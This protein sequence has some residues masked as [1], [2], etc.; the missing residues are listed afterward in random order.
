MASSRHDTKDLDITNASLEE[1][2]DNSSDSGEAGGSMAL[3]S[4]QVPAAQP[5]AVDHRYSHPRR[6]FEFR[7]QPEL[8][9]DQ[10]SF[11][12]AR[13]VLEVRMIS[14]AVGRN[15]LVQAWKEAAAV[16]WRKLTMLP[17]RA[18]F[19]GLDIPRDL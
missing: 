1:N 8:L 10:E 2:D 4:E 6:R 15:K 18:A 5:M 7:A 14:Q 3:I 12:V 13:S 19:A 11:E 17:S 16:A 9:L